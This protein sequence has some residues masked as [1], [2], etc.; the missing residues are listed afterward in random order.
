MTRGKPYRTRALAAGAVALALAFP[1][2]VPKHTLANG[3]AQNGDQF[4]PAGKITIKSALRVNLTRNFATLPLHRGVAG[5]TT[6]WY[7]ITD[8]SDAGV[9]RQLGLN[10]A[11]PLANIT[12]GCPGCAQEVTAATPH[13][14]LGRGGAI[15]FQGMPDFSPARV[16]IPGPTAFPPLGAAPGAMGDLHYSPFVRLQGSPVVY[17][18]P[19]VATGNGPFDVTHH[20][21]T[22]DRV[23][24]IDTKRMTVDLL[25]V[26]GF[27]NGQPILYLSFA[28]S[29][30]LSAVI[31]RSDF[32]P[33]LSLSP[34]ANGEGLPGSARAEIFTFTNAR[35][36]VSSP[37]AQGLTHVIVDGHNTED[38]SLRNTAAQEALRRGGD[39][40]NVFSVFPTLRDPAL[41][42]RYSPLW[43][44]QIGVWSPFAV[45]HKLNVA[46]TDA[47]VIRRLA[48]RGLVTSPG[49]TPLAPAGIVIDCPAL[50]FTDKMP[51]TP[52]VPNP[53][54][55]ITL[56]KP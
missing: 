26:R 47:N 30:V 4:L 53:I 22:Q 20:T 24:G 44:L 19:I 12:N 16:L 32:T 48:I 5:G 2:A 39:A 8:A 9:A 41:A 46:Q 31:E 42:A 27:G 11:P 3:V 25:F 36:G 1:I 55:P 18:A 23:L 33:G 37:P 40:H 14:S 17:N 35:T 49:G 43:D 13:T 6:V 56:P 10:F 21:N 29:D 34:F 38:E 52:Q 7:V 50:A 28:D 15:T 54:K 51:V 45:A